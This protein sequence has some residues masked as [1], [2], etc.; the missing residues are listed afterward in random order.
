VPATARRA[1]AAYSALAHTFPGDINWA[2]E[3]EALKALAGG[4]ARIAH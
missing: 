3:D 4:S 1:A 2:T